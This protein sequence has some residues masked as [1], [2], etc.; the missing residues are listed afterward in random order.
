MGQTAVFEKLLVLAVLLAFTTG[1]DRITTC[2]DFR[3]AQ[4]KQD[5]NMPMA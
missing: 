1:L 4:N 2:V 5:W 3:P